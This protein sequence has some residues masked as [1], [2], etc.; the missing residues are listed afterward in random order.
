MSDE[1][2]SQGRRP[3]QRELRSGGADAFGDFRDQLAAAIQGEIVPKLI[4]ANRAIGVGPAGQ[5][6]ADDPAL[7][8]DSGFSL[9]RVGRDAQSARARSGV[10]DVA[11]FVRLL[12]SAS[13]DAAPAFVEVLM[14]RGLKRDEIMMELLAP[15]ARLIGDMWSDDSCSFADVMIVVTRLHQIMNGLRAASQPSPS[16]GRGPSIL[17]ASAPGENHVFGVAMAE[18]FFHSA[19]WRTELAMGEDEGALL[20]RVAE[21]PF[22][23]L[24][25][26]LSHE[27]LADALAAT[28][29]Q[30]RSVSANRDIRVLAGGPAFVARPRL[31]VSLGVDAV[32]GAGPEAVAQAREAL[33]RKSEMSL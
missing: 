5:A 31:S 20:A 10:V 21:Q 14:A 25:L 3:A 33:A 19:G 18:S 13:P 16:A 17:L 32:L 24:G 7:W 22:D 1:M 28:I 15:A 29:L 23:A 8:S 26:S 4:S 12:R 2:G 27:G 30:V 6:R 9:E 11:R